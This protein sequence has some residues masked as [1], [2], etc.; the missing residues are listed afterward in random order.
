VAVAGDGRGRRRGCGA[1]AVATGAPS[2][3]LGGVQDVLLADAAADAGA[4]DR[5]QVDAVLLASLRTSGVT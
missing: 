5:S 3:R 4:G 2:W 1:G